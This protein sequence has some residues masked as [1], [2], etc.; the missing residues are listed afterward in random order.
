MGFKLNVEKNQQHTTVLSNADSKPIL[1]IP[2]DE[3]AEIARLAY[4]FSHH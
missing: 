4:S 1:M 2:A 3:E